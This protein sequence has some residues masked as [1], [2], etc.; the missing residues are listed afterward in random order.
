MQIEM[1]SNPRAFVGFNNLIIEVISSFLME[2]AF[3]RLSVLINNKGS[4][5][6]FSKGVQWAAQNSL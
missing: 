5:L 1:S 4:L 3:N 2:T 6:L